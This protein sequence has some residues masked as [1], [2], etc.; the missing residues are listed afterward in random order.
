MAINPDVL[1]LLS[2]PELSVLGERQVCIYSGDHAYTLLFVGTGGHQL[3]D[4]AGNGTTYDT[5]MMYFVPHGSFVSLKALDQSLEI[6]SVHFRAHTN[7]CSGLCPSETVGSKTYAPIKSPHQAGY[8]VSETLTG[9]KIRLSKLKVH[10][11]ALN[12]SEGMDIWSRSIRHLLQHEDL[13]LHFFDSKVEE[14]FRLIALD[15][16]PQ[17]V[18]QF[19]RFYHCRIMGF[20]ERI[21]QILS[22]QTEVSTLYELGETMGLNEA[23]FKRT[24]MGEFSQA[25][26]DWLTE[27]RARLIYKELALTDKPFK[28]LSEDYGFCSVS[29]F[30]AFCKINL[31]D[32]PRN[33]RERIQHPKEIE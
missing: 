9:S 6:L 12:V 22:P 17:E 29:H 4:K 19:L 28:I 25:P 8:Q 11:C 27:Q 10:A 18:A 7:L 14:F 15:Y 20:R 30:G 24:F 32:S 13:P 2:R 16:K 1:Y 31:G 3:L 23:T 33:I 21:M 26:R 5:A